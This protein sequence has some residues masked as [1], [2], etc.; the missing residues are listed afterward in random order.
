[1]R[2]FLRVALIFG[3]CFFVACS[4]TSSNF[5]Y[6]ALPNFKNYA[7][8]ERISQPSSQKVSVRAIDLR[9]NE[10]LSQDFQNSVLK[11]RIDEE[12]RL[13]VQKLEAQSRE[14]LAH[15]GY[16]VVQ[17]GADYELVHAVT[18][19]IRELNPQRSEQWLK[20]EAINSSLELNLYS[21][22]T[23]QSLRNSNET[24][25]INTATA[26]DAPVKITYASKDGKGVGF[27]KT[28][29]SS[30]PTQ[31]NRELAVAAVDIDNA[32]VSFYNGV[33]SNLVANLSGANVASGAN[34]NTAS[35]AQGGTFNKALNPAN[36]ASNSS[37]SLNST[38]QA[39][40]ETPLQG[41]PQSLP[42]QSTPQIQGT[43]SDNLQD[44]QGVTIF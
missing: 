19:D 41:S 24:R 10:A 44:N 40:L 6:L 7:S 2:Y 21:T 31:V 37:N 5:T 36:P 16:E 43:P 32:F 30:V 9:C 27:F 15:K 13:L 1:M 22:I 3:A 17:S 33:L 25:Q 23:L 38:P 14:I 29:L 35:G 20:E 26:L 34:L 11:A 42:P 4:Q 18:L 28:T 12:T 39:P 8:N